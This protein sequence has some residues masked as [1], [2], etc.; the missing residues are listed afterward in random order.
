MAIVRAAAPLSNHFAFKAGDI[1]GCQSGPGSG[2]DDGR[3]ETV[4]FQMLGVS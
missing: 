1:E 3:Q 2:L 4:G